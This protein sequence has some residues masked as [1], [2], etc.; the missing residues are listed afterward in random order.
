MS[1]VAIVLILLGTA[2]SLMLADVLRADLVAICLAVVL[3]LVGVLSPAEA[4]SGLSSAPVVTLLAVFILTTGLYR[5]GVT[6]RVGTMLQ[7]LAGESFN[8]LLVLSMLGGAFLAFFMNNIAAAAVLMPALTDVARRTKRSP[9]K[10]LMP[11]AFA[12]NLGGMATLLGTSNILVSS[13]LAKLGEPGFGLLDFVPVGLPVLA[14]GVLYT[15]AFGHRL[16]PESGLPEKFR[17]DVLPTELRQ[18]YA[19][20]ERMR[21]VRVPVGSPL[22]GRTIAESG[23]S[24]DFGLSVLAVVQRGRTLRAPNPQ[25]IFEPGD[26]VVLAGRAE[27]VDEFVN[28]FGAEPVERVPL[29]DALC[30]S[31]VT[32]V[33]AVVPPRSQ[34]EGKTLQD[35]RFRDRFGLSVVALWQGGRPRRTD[36][37]QTPLHF[38]DGLLIYGPVTRLPIL[39]ESEDFLVLTDAPVPILTGRGWLS[40]GI[41]AAT[42]VIVAVNLVPVHLGMMLGAVAMLISGCL[43]MDEAYRSVEWR[44]VFVVAGMLSGGSALVASGAA[45][46]I[47]QRVVL[48]VTGMPPIVLVG[49]MLVLATVLSQV[50]SGQV[51]AVVLTPVAIVAAQ[52]LGANPRAI[53]MAVAV[54]CSTVFLTPTSHPANV[55]VMG[56]GGYR[57]RDFVRVGLPLTIFAIVIALLV[58]PVIFPL[59]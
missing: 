21:Q 26:V 50:M 24:R 22:S 35:M 7:R 36:V 20:E 16:L 17:N 23:A 41:L 58:L 57:P 55:L 3:A 51:T 59:S 12:V 28:A 5:T 40:V 4:F 33:E 1:Q 37:G 48:A 8:R 11:L 46:W 31:R 6:R 38:G 54:G 2:V 30:D 42:L 53:A 27:R 15:V 32:L 34:T 9:S 47:A 49:G 56:P 43:S 19:L 39:Q 10:L 18:T 25:L 45:E 52:Q 44:A 14:V 29:D 13:A